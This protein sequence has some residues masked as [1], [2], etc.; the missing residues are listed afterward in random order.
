MW[1]FSLVIQGTFK[2]LARVLNHSKLAM[3][4][5]SLSI[6]LM[7]LLNAIAIFPFSMLGYRLPLTNLIKLPDFITQVLFEKSLIGIA[8][9]IG[10]GLFC[11]V[12]LKSSQTII[13]LM[14]KEPL[15]LAIKHSW[16]A[17]TGKTL[18]YLLLQFILNLFT[19]LI[20]SAVI[21]GLQTLIDTSTG[22]IVRIGAN[23]LIIVFNAGIYLL[24]SWLLWQIVMVTIFNLPLSSLR[25]QKINFRF[26]LATLG[27]GLII[28]I[29]SSTFNNNW[30]QSITNYPLVISHRGS[31]GNN[32][33]P[34]SIASL[35]KTIRSAHPDYI[36]MDVQFTKDNQFIVLHDT[37]LKSLTGV[38]KTAKELT[39]KQIT[40]LKMHIDGHTANV[41]SFKSY[42][43][44]ANKHHQKLLVEL[45]TSLVANPKLLQAFI[46]QFGTALVQ[47]KAVIHSLNKNLLKNLKQQDQKLKVGFILP[48][49]TET[50]PKSNNAFY[51]VEYTTLTPNLV[52]EI[53]KQ[54]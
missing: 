7:V 24:S 13:N 2:Y 11:L 40:A 48:Y 46:N 22:P 17:I 47:N 44:Y 8:V 31:N 15:F 39:L 38:D 36:E 20:L 21:Y 49:N 3:R 33:A 28:G 51:T 41:P 54:K 19:L 27:I 37:N 9:T 42:L 45:K 16:S 14:Q 34:N 35:K 5:F 1:L 52:Q 53:H 23:C 26:I 10:L 32:G 12:L 4:P 25:P 50:L 43:D 30:F 29:T 6:M 18:W